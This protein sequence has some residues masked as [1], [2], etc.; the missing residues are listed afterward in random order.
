[1]VCSRAQPCDQPPTLSQC[2]WLV[3]A[4]WREETEI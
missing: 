1:M 3:S 2:V 4:V